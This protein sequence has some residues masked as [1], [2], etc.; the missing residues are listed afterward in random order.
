MV[1]FTAVD[2]ASETA[3]GRFTSQVTE[4]LRSRDDAVALVASPTI[5]KAEKPTSKS[6]KP[7]PEATLALETGKKLLADLKFDEAA[8]ALK[9]GIELSLAEPGTADY[10]SVL[11]AHVSLAVAQFRTGA[12]DDAQKTLTQLARMDPTYSI[13]SGYPP[14]FTREFEKAKKRL[15]KQ[16]KSSMSVEG[17]PGSTVFIDG[18]DLGMVPVLEEGLAFGT[19]YVKIEGSRGERFGQVVEVKGGMAKVKGSFGDAPAKSAGGVADPKVTQS[20]D[21]A[22]LTRVQAYVKAANAEYAVVGIVYRTGDQQLTSGLALYSARRSGFAPLPAVSFDH[23]ALTSN[24][25]AFRLVE[26]I[27]KKVQS[28]GS[29]AALPLS[30]ITK[31]QTKLS[32]V[33]T[34]RDPDAASGSRTVAKPR[35]T[36]DEGEKKPTYVADP[37]EKPVEVKQGQGGGVPG[38]VWIVVGVGLA[39]GAGV[40]GYFIVSEST[41][42]VTGTVTAQW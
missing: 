18:R 3:A 8:P 34:S 19:H 23:E 41:K 31:P 7:N 33:A 30:L 38:W 22:T 32:R 39:A 13:P 15:D 26:E 25:E 9:K 5:N 42:P 35:L 1:P 29:S 11:E 4:E 21:E 37:V 6:S 14:A 28:Y 40:G 20:L 16:G 27:V 24:V 2:D 17:P 12:E 36:P 10:P